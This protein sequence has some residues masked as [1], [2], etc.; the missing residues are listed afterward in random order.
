MPLYVM[1]RLTKP[2]QDFG[3]P[4]CHGKSI[5]DPEFKNKKCGAHI[6]PEVELRAHV[7]ALGM[8]FYQGKQFPEEYQNQI[9]LAEHGSWNRAKPQ[10][11]RLTLVRL[12]K[13]GEAKAESFAEGW[14]QGDDVWGR[15]VDVEIYKD[16]SLLV[17]DDK[18]GVIYQISYSPPPHRKTP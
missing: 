2:G 18:A 14:L 8:R 9:I 12:T 11:Y 15:P 6:P 17:S 3:F 5:S 13:G 7:A 10:G 16:G 1:N 4:Y